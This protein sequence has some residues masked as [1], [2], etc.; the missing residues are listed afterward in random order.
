MRRLRLAQDV[1]ETDCDFIADKADQNDIPRDPVDPSWCVVFVHR[2]RDVPSP[3]LDQRLKEEEIAH[4][5]K[6][7]LPDCH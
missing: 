1:R 5:H 4:R 6:N 2:G 7:E 3:H